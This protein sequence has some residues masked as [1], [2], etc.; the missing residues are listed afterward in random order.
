MCG[1][2][3]QFN[4]L[5]VIKDLFDIEETTCQV[6]PSYNIAP[7]QE[8]LSVIN[9]GGN[10]LG[11]LHWGLIPFWVKELKKSSGII[12]ARSE[13]LKEKPAFKKAFK[14]RRCLIIAD[15]FYEWKK[16]GKN[17][18]PY[19]ICLQSGKSFAFAGLWETWK[20]QE[21]MRYNSCTIITRDA[22]ERISEIHERIPAVL[23]DDALKTWLD[24][25]IRDYSLLES[26]LVDGC[27]DDFHYYPVCDKVNSVKI[28]NPE[29]MKRISP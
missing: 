26:L 21:D 25:D 3:A 1:R 9:H 13:T 10:R 23:T 14:H 6:T 4:P 24:P 27:V 15:G 17:R 28:N 11:K 5:G 2:F 16:E 20:Q 12:N 18:K 29:C 22:S 8:V 7:S 19:Y